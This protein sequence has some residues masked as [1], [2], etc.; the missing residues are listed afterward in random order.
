MKFRKK[1]WTYGKECRGYPT[2]RHSLFGVW[3]FRYLAAKTGTAQWDVAKHLMAG[4]RLL[5]HMK[6]RDSC[7]VY[8]AG[9]FGRFNRWSC[10]SNLESISISMRMMKRRLYDTALER[11]PELTDRFFIKEGFARFMKNKFI[12]FSV[13]RNLTWQRTNNYQRNKRDNSNIDTDDD[14]EM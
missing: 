11:C 8:R 7:C 6:I 3:I 2:R 5:H 10:S 14:F 12:V 9:W 13:W 4:L 1:P